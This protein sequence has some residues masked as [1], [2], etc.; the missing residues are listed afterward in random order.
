MP[1]GLYGGVLAGSDPFKYPEPFVAVFSR[2]RGGERLF[3]DYFEGGGLPLRGCYNRR[4]D[5]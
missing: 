2:L 3:N 4:R 1:T 5:G